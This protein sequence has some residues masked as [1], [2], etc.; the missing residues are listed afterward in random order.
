MNRPTRP[1]PSV[2]CTLLLSWR[3]RSSQIEDAGTCGNVHPRRVF[4]QHSTG[5][6]LRDDGPKRL[7]G[8]AYPPVGNPVLVSIIVERND[9]FFE[10]SIERLG[11][12]RVVV[13]NLE[14]FGHIADS[15]AVVS[16]KAFVP[17]AVEH[18]HV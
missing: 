11:I 16:I 18:T 13:L 14:T 1:G 12:C 10:E 4:L 2:L 17:P 5:R 15:P 6:I 9:L 8:H 7:L 3:A